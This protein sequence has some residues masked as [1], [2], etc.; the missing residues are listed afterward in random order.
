MYVRKREK[1]NT[2]KKQAL[3]YVDTHLL[4]LCY[5]QN[6]TVKSKELLYQL[7]KIFQY[8]ETNVMHFV[9]SFIKN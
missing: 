4:H 7:L 6:I 2:M 5:V 1:W 3:F 9:F 8:N